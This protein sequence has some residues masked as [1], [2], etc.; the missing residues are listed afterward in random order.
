MDSKS[1]YTLY[2]TDAKHGLGN[3]AGYTDLIQSNVPAMIERMVMRGE[4][5]PVEFDVVPQP[6]TCPFLGFYQ[7][8]CTYSEFEKRANSA[9][10]FWHF[11]ESCLNSPTLMEYGKKYIKDHPGKFIAPWADKRLALVSNE[12]LSELPRSEARVQNA[13]DGHERHHL[14]GDLL[15]PSTES[16]RAVGTAI[17]N[18]AYAKYSEA[19]PGRPSPEN[20]QTVLEEWHRLLENLLPFDRVIYPSP[21]KRILRNLELKHYVRQ[22]ELR[23]HPYFSL[24]L[25]LLLQIAHDSVEAKRELNPGDD[26]L[27]S[28]IGHKFDIVSIDE[29]EDAE[30]WKDVTSKII[31]KHLDF[32]ECMK[33]EIEGMPYQTDDETD[34]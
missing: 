8:P 17:L 5:D 32:V 7:V 18:N 12:F 10:K 33:I 21:D 30:G 13:N 31:D 28:W 16:L 4:F 34:Y 14:F 1:P 2:C 23:I 6:P 3:I 26:D 11:A 20:L 27:K 19:N 15:E 25:I 24:G 22:D 9:D 29:I